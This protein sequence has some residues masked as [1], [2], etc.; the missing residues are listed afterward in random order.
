MDWLPTSF[1]AGLAV[2][3]FAIVVGR[4]KREPGR[5]IALNALG[6]P[7]FLIG[8]GWAGE[9]GGE[10]FWAAAAA[11]L[12]SLLFTMAANRHPLPGSRRPSRA[13]P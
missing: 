1:A 12:G 2:A 13:H 6:W 7:L 9:V 3:L 5:A 11:S 4:I 8:I 10:A